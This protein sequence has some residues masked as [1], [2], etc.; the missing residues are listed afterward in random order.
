[1]NSKV[2]LA[3]PDVF[4]P[5]HDTIFERHTAVC[6][7][8]GLSAL[9]PLDNRLTTASEIFTFN[10]E[11]LTKA[12]AVIANITPF[13]GPHCDVG[14]AWEM[15]FAF[16]HDKPVFAFS[17]D[18]RL[19]MERITGTARSNGRDAEGRFVEPFSLAENLMIAE[20]VFDRTVFPTFEA[21]AEAAAH[22]FEKQSRKP[23]RAQSA[24]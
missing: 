12:D 20:S 6:R 19:L 21:A 9:I 18:H 11:L 2:Y 10:V 16:A 22:Y 23:R 13:R 24:R 14:T 5:D 8:L 1:M 15:A 4:E 17:S 7:K 3:G